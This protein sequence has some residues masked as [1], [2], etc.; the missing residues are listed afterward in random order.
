MLLPC[1]LLYGVV[2]TFHMEDLPGQARS[3]AVHPGA[4]WHFDSGSSWGL[5]R[6]PLQALPGVVTV[7]ADSGPPQVVWGCPPPLLRLPHWAVVPHRRHGTFAVLP[8]SLHSLRS[9]LILCCSL[10]GRSCPCNS[11]VLRRH[12]VDMRRSI[13]HGSTQV[14]LFIE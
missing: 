2:H 12:P 3:G 9:A 14:L 13:S 4:V 5:G 1:A 6:A 7:V 8:G 11:G 10:G